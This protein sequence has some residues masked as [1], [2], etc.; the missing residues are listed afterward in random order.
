LEAGGHFFLDC[1][2]ERNIA[3]PPPQPPSYKQ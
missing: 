1:R 3:T 2:L